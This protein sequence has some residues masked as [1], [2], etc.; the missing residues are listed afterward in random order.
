MLADAGRVGWRPL[1]RED[2]SAAYGMAQMLT[3]GAIVWRAPGIVMESRMDSP[4]MSTIVESY[5]YRLFVRGMR[6]ALLFPVTLVLMV[7]VRL[8]VAPT[9]LVPLVI[10]LFV[11]MVL[12]IITGWIGALL[13]TRDTSRYSGATSGRVDLQKSWDLIKRAITDTFNFRRW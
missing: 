11:A 4:D 1:P 2:R 3:S 5:R 7:L 6:V 13:L 12:G 9:V 8:G 10:M